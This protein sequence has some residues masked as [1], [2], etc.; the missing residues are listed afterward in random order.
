MQTALRRARSRSLTNRQPE[1]LERS[2][3]QRTQDGSEPRRC[4]IAR[5]I[6]THHASRIIVSGRS[7]QRP[8]PARTASRGVRGAPP[9]GP[10]RDRDRMCASTRVN[11]EERVSTARSHP[12]AHCRV[13]F[14]LPDV[15]VGPTRTQV[16]KATDNTII[17]HERHERTRVSNARGQY[18]R[19]ELRSIT[20]SKVEARKSKS[21]S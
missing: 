5:A 6:I 18:G 2:S 11:R 4:H 3:E 17:P 14:A 1:V 7:R 10:V 19:I 21:K 12:R 16:R 8:A 15:R 20:K 9:A 13:I